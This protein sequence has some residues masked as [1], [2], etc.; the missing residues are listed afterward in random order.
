MPVLPSDGD[1]VGKKG[2][3]RSSTDGDPATGFKRFA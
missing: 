1:I 3:G 2:E